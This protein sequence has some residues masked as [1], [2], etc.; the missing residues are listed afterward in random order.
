MYIPQHFCFRRGKHG[1]PGGGA[2]HL[3]F[4]REEIHVGRRCIP[5]FLRAKYCNCATFGRHRG[6]F[7]LRDSS[8]KHL[9]DRPASQVCATQDAHFVTDQLAAVG[10]VVCPLQ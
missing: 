5:V 7:V 10:L 9:S 8:V 3:T 6:N 1:A 4:P 2:L